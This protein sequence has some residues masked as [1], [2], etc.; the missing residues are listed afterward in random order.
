MK[1]PVDM[2]WIILLKKS[3]NSW[4]I[5][6]QV[7]L[8]FRLIRNWF[9]K[10][11]NIDSFHYPM[12][13]YS[14]NIFMSVILNYRT[15]PFFMLWNYHLYFNFLETTYN[16]K[17]RLISILILQI[18]FFL[19][20]SHKLGKKNSEATNEIIFYKDFKIFKYH[21]KFDQKTEKCIN[22]LTSLCLDLDINSFT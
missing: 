12:A 5:A 4:K 18:L 7:W 9:F 17:Y 10:G 1:K 21:L 20:T 6:S 13:F 16:W 19:S 11:C 15:T 3:N 14:A 22:K 2:Q 8:V